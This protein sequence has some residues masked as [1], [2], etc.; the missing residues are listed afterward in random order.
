[1]NR[2][3]KEMTDYYGLISTNLK[4][5]KNKKKTTTIVDEPTNAGEM[6]IVK[7]PPTSPSLSLSTHIES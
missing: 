4:K 3:W 7:T 2:K 5:K 1:M 6:G